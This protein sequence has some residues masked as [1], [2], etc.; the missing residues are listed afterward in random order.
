MMRWIRA[1][2]ITIVIALVGALLLGGATAVLAAQNYA[3]PGAT[4]T[5]ANRSEAT[6]TTEPQATPE[7]TSQRNQDGDQDDNSTGSDAQTLSGVIQSVSMDA[8]HLI[9]LPN[10]Q[11]ETVTVAFDTRTEIDQ[12]QGSSPLVAGAQVVVEVV[13]QADGTLYAIEISGSQQGGDDQGNDA[14]EH[15]HQEQST[16]TPGADDHS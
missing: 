2:Q 8:H 16:P 6:G 14:G 4:H 12:E 13:K 3:S 11:Q 9:L 15:G 7:S 5:Q 1:R 10:G